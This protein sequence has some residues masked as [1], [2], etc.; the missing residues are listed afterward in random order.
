MRYDELAACS[1]SGVPRHGNCAVYIYVARSCRRCQQSEAGLGTKGN[2][3]D[4]YTQTSRKY[5]G[6]RPWVQSYVISAIL[7]MMR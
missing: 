1:R 4:R 2:G 6:D 3:D 5:A 7:K